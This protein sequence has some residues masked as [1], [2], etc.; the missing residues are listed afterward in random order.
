[1]IDGDHKTFDGSS[2]SHTRTEIDNIDEKNINK[3][4]RVT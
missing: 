1:M 4:E 2:Y 3:S